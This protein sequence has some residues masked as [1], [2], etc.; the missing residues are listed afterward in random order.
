MDLVAFGD[1]EVERDQCQRIGLRDP[2]GRVQAGDEVRHLVE[3]DE[4][5][6]MR[7]VSVKGR[8]ILIL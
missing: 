5:G 2:Q 7:I 1:R 4:L 3:T 6:S 8:Q